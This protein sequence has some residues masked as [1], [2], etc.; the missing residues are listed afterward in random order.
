MEESGTLVVNN[1]VII[2]YLMPLVRFPSF[3]ILPVLVGITLVQISAPVNSFLINL[4]I[5][6]LVCKILAFKFFRLSVMKTQLQYIIVCS[7]FIFL[8]MV[9]FFQALFDT[10]WFRIGFWAY[11]IQIFLMIYFSCML[12]ANMGWILYELIDTFY[13]WKRYKLDKGWEFLKNDYER[14]RNAKRLES[15]RNI[16]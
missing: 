2:D 1:R 3:V 11:Q 5:L 8:G 7:V 9:N 13:S 15:I 12:I 10:R 6:V 16:G 4:G 14:F